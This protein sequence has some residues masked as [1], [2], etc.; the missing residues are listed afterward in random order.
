MVVVS[1]TDANEATHALILGSEDA[2]GAATLIESDKIGHYDQIH[3]RKTAPNGLLHDL[4]IVL[5]QL[6]ALCLVLF[7][8]RRLAY[9]IRQ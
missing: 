1:R 8:R 7:V 3:V 5:D 9:Q 4:A 6:L 2:L